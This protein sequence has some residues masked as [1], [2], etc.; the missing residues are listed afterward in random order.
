MKQAF[1]DA[2]VTGFKGDVVRPN[3]VINKLW[4]LANKLAGDMQSGFLSAGVM[5]SK[6]A[7][8]LYGSIDEAK[9]MG[10]TIDDRLF[11]FD[12]KTAAIDKYYQLYFDYR[13]KNNQWEEAYTNHPLGT[14]PA[15]W[16]GSKSSGSIRFTSEEDKISLEEQMEKEMK[17]F[18]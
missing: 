7:V 16:Y 15:Q 12:D 8:E 10:A 2:S 18:N 9:A 3:F 5:S 1:E 4:G 17:V 11:S 6:K 14:T 13:N